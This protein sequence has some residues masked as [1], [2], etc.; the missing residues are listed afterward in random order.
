MDGPT[1]PNDK[2]THAH[3]GLDIVSR[4]PLDGDIH[5]VAITASA[6]GRVEIVATI[7]DE[8]SFEETIGF[9]P[10]MDT[11]ADVAAK[12]VAAVMTAPMHMLADDLELYVSGP[13]EK[14]SSEFSLER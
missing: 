5:T 9:D 10:E 6:H 12:A 13:T 1:D 11:P 14:M 7:G 3:G 2:I 8:P 4:T